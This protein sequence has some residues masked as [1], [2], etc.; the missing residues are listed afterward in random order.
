MFGLVVILNKKISFLHDELVQLRADLNRPYIMPTVID[1]H[2]RILTAG[3]ASPA[4][5]RK[6]PKKAQLVKEAAITMKEV[7]PDLFDQTSELLELAAQVPNLGAQS[8][9]MEDTFDLY[10]HSFLIPV[11]RADYVTD[12]FGAPVITILTLMCVFFSP[13]FSNIFTL[14]KKKRKPESIAHSSKTPNRPNS[15]HQSSRTSAT[16]TASKRRQ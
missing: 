5:P 14:P 10:D 12:M 9:T 16:T 13:I 15:H 3:A 4:V 8:I 7:L 1:N 2:R 11:E 6:S